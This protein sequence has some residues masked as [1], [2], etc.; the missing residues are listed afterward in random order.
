[1]RPPSRSRTPVT[2]LSVVLFACLAT[3][4]LGQ[5]PPPPPLPNPPGSSLVNPEPR[6]LAHVSVD[7]A[8]GLYVEGQTLAVRFAA[9]HTAHLY[10]LYHQADGQCVLLFPNPA[11]R[12]NRVPARA[13][14]RVPGPGEP[15]RFRIRPPFGT[16]T[17]QVL[18]AAA[19]VDEL[20]RLALSGQRGAPAV[21]PELLQAVH[22]RLA[23]QNV[24][25][26]EHRVALRTR[27]SAAPS[28]ARP[29]AR[30]GLF[31]GIGK[32]LH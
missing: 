16:E 2:G 28:P 5:Q 7:H 18:A 30:V 9:E 12:D 8:D 23:Q 15:F 26:T 14:V 19:P 4:A 3:A 6:F 22:D 27:T 25:W 11:R 20:D 29:A 32:Y 1:M 24:P 17:L 13:V 21:P 31:I 10:L